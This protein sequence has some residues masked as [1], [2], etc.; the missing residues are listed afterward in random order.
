MGRAVDRDEPLANDGGRF[1]EDAVRREIPALDRDYRLSSDDVRTLKTVSVFRTVD[2]RDV[3]AKNVKH[4]VQSGLVE[5]H[6]VYVARKGRG[7]GKRLEVF[8]AT[9]KGRDVLESLRPVDDLQRLHCGLVKKNELEHD[10]AIYPA[11]LEQAEEIEKAGGQVKRVVL[12]YE[13]KSIVNKEMNKKSGPPAEKRREKFWP[14]IWILRSSRGSCR[15]PMCGSNMSMS[16]GS[17]STG[18]WR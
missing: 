5:K 15:C 1:V 14:R 13:L 8:T 16:T 3:D 6:E 11:Y 7:A 12:D 2:A 4:L 18:T 9:G 10:A 17:N